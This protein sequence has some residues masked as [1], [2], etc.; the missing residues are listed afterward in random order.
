MYSAERS[1]PESQS[2]NPIFQR[3]LFAYEQAK[4]LVQ[5]RVLEI[6][7]GTGYGIS[8][9]AQ[10]ATEYVAIDKFEMPALLPENATFQ[11]VNLPPLP[12]EDASFD[13]V[14]SFQ[15]IE[16]IE[17]DHAF[18]SEMARVLKPNGIAILTTPNIKMTLTRNPW[19]VREYTTQQLEA[20]MLKFFAKVQMNG[21]FG[22]ETAMAY[23]DANKKSVAKFKRLDI[24][25]LEHKLPRRILQF[26]YDL[27]NR[28]NRLRL[29]KANIDLVQ[30]LS[31]NDFTRKTADDS[32]FDL[33]VVATKSL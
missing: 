22:N 15:V 25:D 20:L 13:V 33:F 29:Q 17:D 14:V 18:V 28:L 2:D 27:L 19:H 3:H 26:P 23:Y 9:L 7:C 10:N 12:F 5:G 24:F 16:H 32:C 6:G 1:S 31:T 30:V 11:Q 4:P 21:I 8:I